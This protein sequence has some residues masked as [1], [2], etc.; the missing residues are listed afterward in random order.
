MKRVLV[1][2]AAT[3]V[4]V[5]GLAVGT[6]SGGSGKT[7][8]ASNFKFSPKTITINKGGRVTWQNVEGTHT[9]T[10]KNGSY[11]KTISGHK[12]VSRRFTHSGTYR[13][14]CT[15]HIRQGMKGKVVVG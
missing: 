3:A 7:V 2:L 4:L 10:F 9:V 5:L 6:A 12:S 14:V 15:L 8:K 13:Y 1:L 11:D